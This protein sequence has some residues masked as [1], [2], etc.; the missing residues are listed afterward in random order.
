MYSQYRGN[1][2]SKSDNWVLGKNDGVIKRNRISKNA[3]REKRVRE[4]KSVRAYVR[5][6]VCVCGCEKEKFE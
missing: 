1:T 2:E 5:V 3:V 4:K 6:C